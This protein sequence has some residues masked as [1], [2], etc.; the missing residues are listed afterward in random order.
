M[1]KKA[2]KK[3]K[4]VGDMPSILYAMYENGGLKNRHHEDVVAWA[5]PR[6]FLAD[7]EVSALGECSALVAVYRLEGYAKVSRIDSR[8]GKPNAS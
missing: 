1:A 2:V 4:L 6:D 7:L 8:A 3:Q 5:D